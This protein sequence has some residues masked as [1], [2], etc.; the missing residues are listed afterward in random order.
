MFA[1]SCGAIAALGVLFEALRAA[2][3]AA[4]A[5]I[6]ACLCGARADK[7]ARLGARDVEGEGEGDE[8]AGLLSG[9][10]A[11]AQR[12]CVCPMC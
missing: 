1:L 6:A 5:Q 2:Q 9:A 10:R 4:D 7:A 11:A 3:G 8:T 12:G